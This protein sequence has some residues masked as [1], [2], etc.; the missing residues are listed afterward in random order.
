M[1]RN[2]QLS[3]RNRVGGSDGGGSALK[4]TA[5]GERGS[6]ICVMTE[7]QVRADL[8][9]NGGETRLSRSAIQ[10]LSPNVCFTH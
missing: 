5:G 3:E 7:L 10:V 2:G 1:R 8:R 9:V 6:R 4:T